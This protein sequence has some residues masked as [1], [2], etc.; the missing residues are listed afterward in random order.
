MCFVIENINILMKLKDNARLRDFLKI[1]VSALLKNTKWSFR[2]INKPR[3]MYQ[4][5]LLKNTF[6]R[7]F[8][9]IIYRVCLFKNI[10]A[11]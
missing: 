9:C 6:F 3:K 11:I 7:Y 2:L 10:N 1:S 4:C 8:L 5:V